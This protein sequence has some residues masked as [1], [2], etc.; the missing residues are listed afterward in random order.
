VT[1]LDDPPEQPPPERA[2]DPDGPPEDAKPKEEAKPK[3]EAKPQDDA[4]SGEQEDLDRAKELPHDILIRPEVAARN[5][6]NGSI[7]VEGDFYGSSDGPGRNLVSWMDIT[8]AVA[9]AQPSFVKP[10]HFAELRRR[11]DEEHVVLLAGGGCGN[12][13]T[14]GSAL[15]AAGRRPILELA[16]VSAQSLI[17]RIE[18]ICRKQSAVGVLIEAVDA[19]TL[20]GF[21]GFELRRLRG[22]LAKGGS[23]ILTTRTPQGVSV[24]APDL[25]AIDGVPPDAETIV[26]LLARVQRLPASVLARALAALERLSAPV[27]PAT[28]V[29]L[30]NAA[31]S[32]VDDSPE[33][34]ASQVSWQSTALDEWAA[35]RPTAEH[36]ASLTAAAA[37]DGVPSADVE[38]EAKRLEELLEGGAYPAAESR[39]FGTPSRGW[40]AGMVGVGRHVFSTHFGRQ[41]TEVIEI[42]PPHRSDRILQYLWENLGGQFRAPYLDWLRTLPERGSDRVTSSAAVSAGSLFI[43]EPMV[44][45][46]ELLRSW[47]LDGRRSQLACAGLAL[48]V[49][50][51]L[52]A[53]P[54]P[55][56]T[57]AHGW[58]TSQNRCYQRAAIAAYGGLLGAWDPG[59]AAPFH[60]WRVGAETPEL[61]RVADTSLAGLVA[62][63]GEAGRARATVISLLAAEA[64]QKPDPRRSYELLPLVVGRLAGGSRAARE[65]FA[66]LLAEAE[67]ES[68]VK[69]AGLFAQAFDSPRGQASARTAL[70]VVLGALA[71]NRIDHAMVN[72]LI[73]EMK[74][75]TCPGRRS[76]LG[77]QIERALN[78]ERRVDGPRRAVAD[79]VHATFFSST[80]RRPHA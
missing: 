61:R 62:A 75:A 29:E 5:I 11:L 15:H 73:R 34:L 37:L 46:R 8:A 59:S 28:A 19:D 65:S 45:E 9:A 21:A 22:A 68:L 30:V 51:A 13:T 1:D 77:S 3:D 35:E 43:A 38:A 66:A 63:G 49:P 4:T 67:R 41:E 18:R 39:R 7:S 55:S 79:A 78:A 23:V 26:R 58:V 24:L 48:G 57:L 74:A 42:C 16:G 71:G 44:G 56:R 10:T 76:A 50:V 47:A 32:R 70:R 54:T 6:Y 31:Q 60:L 80:V 14:A 53:D 69:L 27:V 2:R 20:R 17:D 64:E 33:Q 52:G 72:R 25:C 12:R 40:P 36:V